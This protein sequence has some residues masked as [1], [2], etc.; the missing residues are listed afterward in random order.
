MPVFFARP[1]R[2]RRSGFPG[3]G[4][5]PLICSCYYRIRISKGDVSQRDM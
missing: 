1:K 2:R 5:K 3:Y 4:T